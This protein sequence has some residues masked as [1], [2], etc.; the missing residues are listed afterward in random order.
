MPFSSDARGSVGDGLDS[1]HTGK[2]GEPPQL[3]RTGRCAEEAVASMTVRDDE[4]DRDEMVPVTDNSSGSPVVV[5]GAAGWLGQNLVRALA[6]Q[7]ERGRIRCLVHEGADA[8]VLE[9]IDPRIEVVAGDVRDPAV[10]DELFADVKGAS[11]IHAAAVIHP[12]RAVRE[13]FDVNVGGTQ[14][15]LDRAR[16][17]GAARFVHVSSNSP[18]GANHANT[19]RFDEDSPFAPYMAY[20]RSKLEAEQL[21]QRSYERGDLATVIVR[22]PW[23]YGPFQPERQTQFLSAVRRGRFPLVGPG[24]QRR[25]MVY[26]GNLVQGVL[27]AERVPAAVGNAYWIADA[28]PYALQDVLRTVR[29]ALAAEGLP[30]SNRRP[31]PIPRLAGVVAEKLDG[32]AQASGRYIQVLHV[33]GELKDTIACDISRARKD[34]GYEPSVALLEG[35]RASVRWCLARGDQL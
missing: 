8:A 15:V 32:L 3:S 1:G 17:V 11:V 12:A 7:P 2:L 33:L 23:F 6:Q 28:E 18:F 30:V 20:G 13:L 21:V 29:D 9:V 31:L 14:L 26:T 19:D 34:L 4:T 35:M 24:T 5:T 27:L 22:P 16:R 10:I 25:S